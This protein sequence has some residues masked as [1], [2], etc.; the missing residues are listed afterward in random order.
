MSIYSQEKAQIS[1][2]LG[3]DYGKSN[4]GLALADYETK[5][6]FAYKVLK[7]NKNLLGNIMEEI[8]Q[9]NVNIIVMGVPLHTNNSEMKEEI[10]KIGRLLELETGIRVEYCNEMFTTKMAQDNLIEKGAKK[11]K[12]YDDQES[13]R[14]ILQE[15]IDNR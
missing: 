9:K 8:N 12:E 13:A 1:H 5:V 10:E 11:I 2:Y 4:V 3:I 7:N 15:W 6:A 14:I